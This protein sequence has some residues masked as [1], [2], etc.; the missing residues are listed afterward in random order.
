M[1]EEEAIFSS[2]AMLDWPPA[3]GC[4][5]CAWRRIYNGQVWHLRS[6]HKRRSL[7][8]LELALEDAEV[9][10]HINGQLQ[11]LHNVSEA[12]L[13]E[14]LQLPELHAL[15]LRPLAGC[16][17]QRA[18]VAQPGPEGIA[19]HAAGCCTTWSSPA[20]QCPPPT[21]PPSTSPTSSTWTT[22]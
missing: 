3:S 9:M 11:R 14:A 15:L 22:W 7:R 6:I 17:H 18:P 20:L 1:L 5:R 10:E 4:I 19:A 12:V 16:P 21:S 13:A 2:G 8:V